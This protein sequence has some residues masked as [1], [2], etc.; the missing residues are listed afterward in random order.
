MSAVVVA[1]EAAYQWMSVFSVWAQGAGQSRLH[2]GQQ[3]MPFN[4]GDFTFSG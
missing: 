4:H 2:L 1:N 3:T